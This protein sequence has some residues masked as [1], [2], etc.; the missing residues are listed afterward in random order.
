MNTIDLKQV[1]QGNLSHK[2]AW[3]QIRTA[4]DTGELIEVV[5]GQLCLGV[6]RATDEKLPQK[7]MRCQELPLMLKRQPVDERTFVIGLSSLVS[8]ASNLEQA[9]LKKHTCDGQQLIS[10]TCAI[11]ATNH[12]TPQFRLEPKRM[13][14]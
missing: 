6:A 3:E 2:N 8:Y 9:V 14:P 12:R 13:D 10:L 7:A 1:P 4:I 11:L 5:F